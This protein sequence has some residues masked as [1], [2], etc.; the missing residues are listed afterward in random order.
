MP[1]THEE[2]PGSEQ[3]WPPHARIL[4]KRRDHIRGSPETR[5]RRSLAARRQG[6]PQEG[7]RLRGQSGAE[8]G[9]GT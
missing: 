6:A 7:L 3:D 1:N 8:P 9:T 5:G 2:P 4:R